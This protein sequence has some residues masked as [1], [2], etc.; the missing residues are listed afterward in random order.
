MQG[1]TK[2]NNLI[3]GHEIIQA[4]IVLEAI[5]NIYFEK[6]LLEQFVFHEIIIEQ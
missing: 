1:I 5:L 2:R 6:K 3:N 4:T